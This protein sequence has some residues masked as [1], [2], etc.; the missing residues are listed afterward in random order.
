MFEPLHVSLCIYNLARASQDSEEKT[1]LHSLGKCNFS[2]NPVSNSRDPEDPG[3]CF[4]ITSMGIMRK[5][6]SARSPITEV[7]QWDIFQWSF[8]KIKSERV[9][10]QKYKNKS[11]INQGFYHWFNVWLC[12]YVSLIKIFQ[13]HTFNICL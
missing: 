9:I 12:P 2:E 4:T 5:L 8:S 10:M 7:C 3:G 6:Y 11:R 1:L 13:Y